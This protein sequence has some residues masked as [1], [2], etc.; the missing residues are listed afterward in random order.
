MTYVDVP[1]PAP[2]RVDEAFDER[3]TVA[4]PFADV[5]GPRRLTMTFV[6]GLA[7]MIGTLTAVGVVLTSTAA[8][9]GVR[10]WDLSISTDVAEHRTAG[11]VDVARF[12]TS[13]GDTLT[14]LT[15]MAAITV[16]L[17]VLRKWWAMAFVPMA[18]LAEITTFLSVNHLVGRER[19]PVDKIGPLPGTFSFPSGHVAATLVCWVGIGVL[20]VAY[21]FVKSGVLVAVAGAAMAAA[22]GW[23]RVYVGM[24]YTI[25]VLFGFAMGF[26]ALVL[27]VITLRVD[28]FA[29]R[30]RG[31]GAS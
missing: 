28:V 29:T 23:A 27:T 16:V 3:S 5:P 21:G 12:I 24:H 26:A 25:D 17:A 8:F 31:D 11:A 14:I 9:E 18:M 4:D 6:L 20:L 22:M 10:D 13:T 1:G 30:S 2:A 15:L 7:A 19:P